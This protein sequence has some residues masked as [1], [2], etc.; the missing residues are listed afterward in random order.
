MI[1]VHE[2]VNVNVRLRLYNLHV[3]IWSEYEKCLLDL[4]MMCVVVNDMSKISESTIAG[5]NTNKATGT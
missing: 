1:N 5:G 4:F 2:C 3:V